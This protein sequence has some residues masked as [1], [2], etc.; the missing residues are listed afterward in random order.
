ME[1][2]AKAR[3]CLS[4]ADQAEDAATFYVERVP[5][6]RI[7]SIVR[8]R[9]DGPPLIV[10]FTVAGTPVMAMNGNPDFQLN[11][12]FSISVLT[13]DQ[14]ETDHLWAAMLEGGGEEGRCGWLK[15]R[16]G[17]HWQIVPKALP[18]L[19][20]TGGEAGPRVQ[21][22]LMG[23]TRIDVAALEAAAAPAR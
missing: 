4:M 6:S 18:R 2:K 12:S 13:E 16:F 10:E 8:P 5:S 23:M 19:M 9:P 11:H 17:V 22:A 14:A 3:A 7:D 20:N 15:D 21:A 1:F